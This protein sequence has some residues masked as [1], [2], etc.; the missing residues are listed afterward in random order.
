MTTTKVR[1]A[2][3]AIER[4]FLTLAILLLAFPAE[5]GFL[6]AQDAPAPLFRPGA[7][8]SEPP[9]SPERTPP[10][11]ALPTKEG[12]YHFKGEKWEE[13]ECAGEQYMRDHPMPTPTFGNSVESKEKGGH[14]ATPLIVGSVQIN[15]GDASIFASETD[16]KAGANAY[17][18]QVNTNTFGCSPCK[19]GS[20][21]APVRGAPLSA[22]EAGDT[23][24]IQYVWQ[25][26]ASSSRLCIWSVDT[27]IA[28]NTGNAPLPTGESGGYANEGYQGYHADCIY[29]S[30]FT[31]IAPLTGT[32]SAQGEAIVNGYVQCPGQVL[33]LKPGYIAGCSLWAL[34]TLPWAQDPF[35][36]I[37]S[38]DKM[39]L[40]GNWTIVSGSILGQGNASHAKFKAA[41]FLEAIGAYSCA[42]APPISAPVACPSEKSLPVLVGHTVNFDPTGESSNL[43]VNPLNFECGPNDCLLGSFLTSPF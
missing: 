26:D 31:S 12:C 30:Q 22:S 19:S 17:S 2:L 32:G 14:P 10:T 40:S 13:V 4:T 23:G 25:S 28:S 20:P 43:T 7:K 38:K 11:V 33:N 27:T 29:P 34:A 8:P 16:S 5:V 36:I 24:W 21:F 9:P 15:W 41:V 3:K 37:A 35:W 6:S 1:R 42:A 39:G 18:I